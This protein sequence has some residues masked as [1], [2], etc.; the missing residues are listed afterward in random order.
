M[1]RTLVDV[2]IHLKEDVGD[3]AMRRL[4]QELCAH[5]GVMSATHKPGRNH[6]MVVAYDCGTIGSANLLAP[7]ATNGLHAQLIGL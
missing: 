7:F 6:L 3:S 1:A 5:D 2:V 4:E